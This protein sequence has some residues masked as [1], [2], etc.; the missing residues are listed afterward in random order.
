MEPEYLQEVTGEEIAAMGVVSAP[1]I[2]TGTPTE[3]KL[4]FDRLV[5]SLVA[6]KVNEVVRRANALLTAEGV[7]VEQEAERVEA[8]DAR[9]T[10]EE[11]RAAAE[12]MRGE[13]EDGRDT[14]EQGRLAAEDVRETAEAAR[15][16]AERKRQMAAVRAPTIGDNGNWYIWNGTE[17]RYMDSGVPATGDRGAQGP[18]G[19]L[20]QVSP[21]MFAFGVSENGHLLVAVN[22]GDTVPPLEIDQRGHLIYKINQ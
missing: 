6:P 13:A 19:V 21:G 3:N 10:A 7:R 1:N 2:L 15:Q 22:E 4:I 18:P 17:E 8:E 16:E 12:A 14:A 20:T 5:A 11:A 9:Q